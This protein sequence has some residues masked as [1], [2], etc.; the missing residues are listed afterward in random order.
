M[1]FPG[2]GVH[3]LCLGL[4]LSKKLLVIVLCWWLALL[5]SVLG[6]LLTVVALSSLSCASWSVFKCFVEVCFQT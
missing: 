6:E 4:K 1:N 5:S 3:L 2:V